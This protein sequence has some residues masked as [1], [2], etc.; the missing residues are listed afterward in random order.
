MESEK[1][2]TAGIHV[3]MIPST[4]LADT[5]PMPSCRYEVLAGTL[6][7]PLVRFAKAGAIVLLLYWKNIT[8]L[9]F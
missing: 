8:N 4:E 1:I 7:G 2:V 5:R 6:N 3:S 9:N